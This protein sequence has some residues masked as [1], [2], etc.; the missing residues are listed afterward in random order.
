LSDQRERLRRLL[1]LVPYV[2]RHP[3]VTVKELAREL[4]VAPADLLQD[5]DLLTLVG[6]PPFSPDDYIDVFVENDRV[7][8]ALDQRLSR[9]PRLTA[10]EAA[11]LAAAARSL[12]PAAECALASAL[13]KIERAL[14]AGA[15]NDYAGLTGRVATDSPALSDV[16]APLAEAAARR[17]EVVLDY[18]TPS[19]GS[20]EKRPVQPHTVFL[21][22]GQWYLSAFCGTRQDERL[23]RVDR[24][25]HLE[26]T[27]RTF[28]APAKQPDMPKTVVPLG[29]G[30][31][32]VIRFSPG[33]APWI[34]ERFG[35]G[36]KPLPDGGVEVRMPAG[37]GNEW[38][39]SYVLFFGGDATVVSPD[40][41]RKAVAGA[42][43]KAAARY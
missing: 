12:K 8:V 25:R 28:P 30:E 42:A 37:A 16:L 31:D 36:A 35:D 21:H 26:V 6:R 15:L 10:A 20:A 34:R 2:A 22:R 23:F 3:G 32:A 27:N 18:F 41:V 43:R 11:A 5:L 4:G 9:P 40:S 1:F 14:P 33:S 39:V 17:R 38:L 7:Y 29:G 19:R 24:I 13:A